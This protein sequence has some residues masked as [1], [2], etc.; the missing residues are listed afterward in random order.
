MNGIDKGI[1][2]PSASIELLKRLYETKLLQEAYLEEFKDGV[3][4]LS[5]NKD[6]L[7]R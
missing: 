3:R 1:E 7:K 2:S 4:W 6:E 5:G